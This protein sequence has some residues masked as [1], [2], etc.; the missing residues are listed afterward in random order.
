MA[1]D[2]ERTGTWGLSSVAEPNCSLPLWDSARYNTGHG[3][4]NAF[5]SAVR[6]SHLAHKVTPGMVRE[7]PY[8]PKEYRCLSITPSSKMPK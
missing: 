8:Q 1:S 5:R 7:D 2:A 6:R 4:D 3:N